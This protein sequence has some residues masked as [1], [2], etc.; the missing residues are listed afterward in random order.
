MAT[1]MVA[2][3]FC[4]MSSVKKA[5]GLTLNFSN[6]VGDNL[7]QLDSVQYKNELA[8]QFTISN[9]KYY[10]GKSRLI[11]ANGLVYKDDNYFLVNAAEPSSLNFFLADIPIAD[12][13]SISF[14]LGVDSIDN[15][16]GVQTGALDPINGMFWAWNTGY[17]FLKLE[18]KAKSSVSSGNMFEY[19]IG[20]YKA[21]HNC[22]RIITIDLQNSPLK[23]AS[24]RYNLIALKTDVLEILKT[25]TTINFSNLSSVIDFHNATTIADNYKDMFRLLYVKNE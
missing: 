9:L 21:P 20:G 25:P 24:E 14:T 7:L 11:S 8:Q 22:I 12:Y 18:G 6:Y 17:V 4:G 10:V 19:H 2:I 15:C 5:G 23:I 16:S 1:F 3:S 13:T